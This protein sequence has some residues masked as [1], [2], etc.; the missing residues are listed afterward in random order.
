MG[1]FV[2][3]LPAEYAHYHNP[4]GGSGCGGPWQLEPDDVSALERLGLSV[5]FY[6]LYNVAIE[7][8]QTLGFWGLGA[9]VFWKKSDARMALFISLMLVSFGAIGF[10]NN[11][12]YALG[13]SHPVW[14]L[15]IRFVIDL[16]VISFFVSFYLFPDGRFVP[17]WTRVLVVV[18]V[19][20]QT[21]Y[22]LFDLLPHLLA[23]VLLLGQLVTL[24]FAQIYRYVRVSGPVERQQTKWVVFGL[25]A[26]IATF[27]GT[28][29]VGLTFPELTQPGV[30]GMLFTL[31]SKTFLNVSQLFIPLS[32]A[33]AI[34]HHR[35]WD[36]DLI[37]K[38]SL[39]YGSLSAVLAAVFAITDTLVLPTL[40]KSILG[41]D[42]P[43]LNAVISAVIIAVL[44]EPLR[45]RIKGGVNKLSDWVAGGVR[46]SKS[47]RL[48]EEDL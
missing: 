32:I 4:C 17:R 9:L 13:N 27:I 45:R 16:A 18:L 36:I 29:L 30:P 1:L 39:V 10:A 42:D 40:V 2:A 44:F 31:G 21:L 28:A 23:G 6:A 47:P 5:G 20:Y 3:G 25:T 11:T 19:V 38:R 12:L 14:W 43:T 8:V 48:T 41:E 46:T 22:S 33:I 15:P 26:A 34:L 24:A 7:V 35:L 37:I